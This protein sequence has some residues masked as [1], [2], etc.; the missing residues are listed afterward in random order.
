M[1]RKD[2]DFLPAFV[3]NTI[4]GGG[5]MSSRLWEEVRE[6]RGLAYTSVTPLK[7]T[8]I[9]SGGVATKNEAVAQ[10]LE[11]IRAEIKRFASEGPTE[12][13][14]R[15]AK[16]YLT[17]SFALRF[18]SNAKIA[19]QL[20][21][22]LQEDLGLDYVD[23]RNGEIEAVTMGDI[24]RAAKR[25]FEGQEPIVIIVGKPV[26]MAVPTAAASGKRS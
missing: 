17:G 20:L 21:W 5:V 8:S 22:I 11:V 24:K 2:K 16:D 25:L 10:S 14:L 1:P 23:R 26:G 18:D 12:K 6:K 7:N 15:D 19:N 9:F 4:L 13:E 3:L